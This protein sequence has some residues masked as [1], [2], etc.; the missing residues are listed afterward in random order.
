MMKSCKLEVCFNNLKVYVLKLLVC[1]QA[2]ENVMRMQW[3]LL[4][5]VLKEELKEEK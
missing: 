4:L 5:E 3:Q 1:K 2:S